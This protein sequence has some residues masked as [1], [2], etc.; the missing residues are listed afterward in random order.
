MLWLYTST[1]S[2][3]AFAGTSLFTSRWCSLRR[4]RN[5]PVLP[6]YTQSPQ[7]IVYTMPGCFF[8]WVYTKRLPACLEVLCRAC[9]WPASHTLRIP[10]L[11]CQ[12]F[13]ISLGQWPQ[14]CYVPRGV[15]AKFSAFF[16]TVWA[17]AEC[18]NKHWHQRCTLNITQKIYKIKYTEIPSIQTCRAITC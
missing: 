18:A 2:A 15:Y 8:F 4:L 14:H 17:P 9:G 1:C 13:C 3:S 12:K 11:K 16:S 5:F 6:T 7:G 10:Y